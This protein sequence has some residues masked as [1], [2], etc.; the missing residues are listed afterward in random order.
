MQ[1]TRRQPQGHRRPVRRLGVPPLR[2]EADRH[3]R[4]RGHR[5]LAPTSPWRTTSSPARP[6]RPAIQICMGL[7]GSGMVKYGVAIGADTSQGAPGDPLEYSA[8]AGGAAYLI[9]SEDLIATH[10]PHLLLHHRHP[11]LLAPGGPA[12]S[13][14][15]RHGSPASRPT[16]S[17]S[18]ACGQG[19]DGAHG[20]EAVRLSIRRL[21]PAQRQV[22]GAGGQ[23]AGL[24]RQADRG[25]PAH[26]ADRQHLLAARCPWAWRRYW[27]W[28]SRATAS[29]SWPTAPAPAATAS[30]SP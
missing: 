17:T 10:Q 23:A 19:P 8:S 1:R 22:P 27:T 15:W 16:S 30:T 28:P 3:H 20:D 4:G 29:S 9:G 6:G 18:C 13:V 7:V 21:P 11:G 24:H 12:L 14:P 25:R 5:D 2:R 26:A